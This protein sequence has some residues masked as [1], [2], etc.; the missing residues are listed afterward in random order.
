MTD[1][2]AAAAVRRESLEECSRDLNSTAE[3]AAGAD[4][5]GRE[6]LGR[7]YC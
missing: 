6:C 2:A 1:P 7:T 3:I 5:D 4:A